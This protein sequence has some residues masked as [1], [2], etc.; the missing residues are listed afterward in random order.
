[1]RRVIIESPY[2]GDVARNVEYARECVRNGLIRGE[3]PFASHLL[4]TQAGI[5]DDRIRQERELGIA[6]GLAWR[7]VA[8]RIIFCID[9]GWSQGMR[10]AFI[11][12]R[13]EGLPY[14]IRKLAP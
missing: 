7:F 14:E 3:A 9:N 4:Y 11:I 13:D 6:A 10:Q 2:Q 8:E 1:M 12:A 5:L